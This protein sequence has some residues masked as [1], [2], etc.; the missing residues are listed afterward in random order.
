[1]LVTG[2]GVIALFCAMLAVRHGAADVVV[3]EASPQRRAVAEALGLA[4]VD[5]ADGQAW[6]AVKQRWRHGPRDAGADVVLQCRGR[7]T[8]LATAL[9]SLRPQGVVVDLAFYQGGAPAVRL[10]E[11][12]HHNGLAV[13]CAQIGRV[14]RG[15]AD[16]WPRPALSAVTLDLLRERGDDVRAHLVTDVLPFEDGPAFLGDLAAGR[17]TTLQ[18]VL[19]FDPA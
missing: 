8:A 15:M 7:D 14:P 10:G 13:V 6:H 1:V 12:F 16:A 2:G 17:R 3:A 18:A 5:D 19:R 11:E 9:K 4:T